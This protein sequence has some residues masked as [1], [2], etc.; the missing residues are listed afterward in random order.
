MANDEQYGG[1]P[2]LAQPLNG[3][4]YGMKRT[5][6]YL[7]DDLQAQLEQASRLSGK[8]KAALIR[9]GLQEVVASIQPRPQ[10]PLFFPGHGGLAERVDELL[11]GF[12]QE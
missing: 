4:V 5:T 11:E 2:T 7:P 6:I 1:A 10:V 8:S 3:T 12:G 9:Q